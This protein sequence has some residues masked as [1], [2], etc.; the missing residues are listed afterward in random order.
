MSK[1]KNQIMKF[2]KLI[3]FT[4]MVATIFS[5]SKSD[6]LD[7]KKEYNSKTTIEAI[8]IQNSYDFTAQ[9]INEFGPKIP[10]T[11]IQYRDFDC[12][13]FSWSNSFGQFPNTL[14]IDFGAGCDINDSVTVSGKITT[15]FSGFMNHS[16]DSIVST[17][18]NFYFNGNKIEG[19]TKVKNNGKNDLGQRVFVKEIIGGKVLFN[20]GE[21]S[22]FNSIRISKY[23]DNGTPWKLKDDQINISGNFSGVSKEGETFEGTI[24]NELEAPFSCECIVKGDI[25]LTIN[26]ESGYNLDYGNGECDKVATLTYP[27]GTQEEIT[28]C[29]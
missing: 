25:D 5:C 20:S 8:S 13:D 2:T 21:T 4:V 16:G 15:T 27:D 18:D 9:A 12:G 19:L 1:T 10:G 29:K 22:T 26:S 6:I 3:V 28:V 23:M 24:K 17:Y 14:T 11:G 7:T